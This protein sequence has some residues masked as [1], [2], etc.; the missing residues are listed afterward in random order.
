MAWSRDHVITTS[1]AANRENAQSIQ[2]LNRTNIPTAVINP[3][4]LTLEDCGLFD[5]TSGLENTCT[6]RKN[7]EKRRVEL[8][9]LNQYSS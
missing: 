3:T 4:L 9:E 6:R 7:R 2:S 8:K 1:S 5:M